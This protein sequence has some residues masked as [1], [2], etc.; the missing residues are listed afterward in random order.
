[1]LSRKGKA[2][3]DSGAAVEESEEV[4]EKPAEKETGDEKGVVH[5]SIS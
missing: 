4:S 1:M 3:R 5:L 2:S